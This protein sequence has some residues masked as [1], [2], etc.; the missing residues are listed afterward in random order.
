MPGCWAELSRLD[1]M[2]AIWLPSPEVRAERERAHFRLHLVRQRGALK[3]RI[4]ATLFAFGCPCPV[5]RPLR[6]I[7]TPAAC[8][9]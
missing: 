9:P 5:K 2:P 3:N 1:L 4:H 6:R 7:G 8:A